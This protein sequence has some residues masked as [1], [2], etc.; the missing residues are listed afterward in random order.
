MKICLSE[1]M[2]GNILDLGGGGEGI[3]G[4]T[5]LSQVAA[6]DYR[7]EELDE[8][9]DGFRKLCMDA[10]QL[11]FADAAFDHVTAFYTMMYMDKE[12]H[13]P[14]LREAKRVLRRGG[15]LHIWDAEI[16]L[17]EPEPFFAELDV[18]TGSEHIHTTYGVV[19]PNAK[20]NAAYFL[21]LCKG[22]GL[23]LVKREDLNGHFYLTFQK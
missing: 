6:I 12:K 4:R 13:E 2:K 21:L 14:A 11:T 17:A 19:K 20:Q 10:A 16:E 9:P 1:T 18:F 15:K 22:L 5:Y 7:Q 3:I 23:E 8:A